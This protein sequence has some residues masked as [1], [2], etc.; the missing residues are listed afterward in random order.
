MTSRE[1]EHWSRFWFEYET[2]VANK[3]E[4]SQVLRTRN[5]QPID[6]KK[7]GITL[8]TVGQQL[9]LCA[10]DILLDLCCGNGLFSAALSGR[11]ARTDS[12]TNSRTQ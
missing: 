10:D 5:K 2:D 9:E 12:V 8:T 3:D 1:N 7:W 11:S 4:Q 6:Q